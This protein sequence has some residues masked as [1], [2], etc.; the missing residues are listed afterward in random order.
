MLFWAAAI[1]MTLIACLAILAPMLRRQP[2][3]VVGSHDIEVYRDQL[4]ELERDSARGL[5]DAGQS[6]EA[7]AEIARRLLK[8]TA[9]PPPQP[10][11]ESSARTVRF[12]ALLAVIAVPLVSWGLYAVIGSPDRPGE[13]LA[14]R[15]AK[16]PADATIDEL[17]ARA[18]LHLKN[19]PDDSRGWDVLGPIYM[20]QS[21]FADAAAA[22]TN[23][24]RL[25]GSSAARE[26][27]LGEAL[28][29]AAGGVVT[30]EAAAAFTRA[31]ALAPADPKAQFF[32]ATALAQQGKLTEA[33]AGWRA[34]KATLPPQS[35]WHGAVD[36]A[37]LAVDQQMAGAAAPAAPVGPNEADIAAAQD[38][39]A[40][41]RTAMIEGMVASLDAKLRADPAD[42]DGWQRLIRAYVV[43]GK[44]EEAREALAR[45]VAGLGSDAAAVQGVTDF[46]ATL[47]V[48]AVQ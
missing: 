38:M 36:Q 10:A 11:P 44:T 9:E 29:A 22:W 31:L 33:G 12:A 21:R 39:T 2:A 16:S 24:I 30:A 20:R 14:E 28:A 40:E 18:E 43:L 3:A 26:S 42:A 1:A 25:D 45:A 17:I 37:I 23:S 47:G 5:I 7:R 13:P 4:S 46:A 8:A 6:E 35:P 34:L 41:D 48:K 15:L 27:G 19:N 32:L